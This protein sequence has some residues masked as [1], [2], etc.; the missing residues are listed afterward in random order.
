M[1]PLVGGRILVAKAETVF[2]TDV[3]AGSYIAGDVLPVDPATIRL[4]P[5]LVE[6]INRATMGYLGTVGSSVGSLTGT[7]SWTQGIRGRGA[8][9]DDSPV[10][11]PEIDLGLR[12]CGLGRT[13]VTTGGSESVAY[14]PVAEGS[15]E[16]LT[17]Y[18][19]Q[20]MPSGNALVFKFVGCRGTAR[21]IGDVGQ[22]PDTIEFSLQG[23][24]TGNI[25]IAFTNGTLA[26]TPKFP[27]LASALLQ[28]GAANYAPA[29]S[30]YALDLGNT[31]VR[32]PN[33]NAASGYNGFAITQRQPTFTFDPTMAREADSGWY[34]ALLAGTLVDLTF[35]QGATQ[36]NRKKVKIN[37]ASAAGGQI[38][39]MGLGDRDGIAA[40]DLP[41]RLNISGTGNNDWQ[42]LFD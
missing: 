22:G 3:L 13:I 6:Y 23:A 40:F 31:L 14:Q 28:V 2:G 34:A 29:W 11:V 20:P 21:M 39:G 12:A 36:Y 27:F 42:I 30:R 5:E 8:A 10:V 9:Y 7:I 19:V 37:A 32:E 26:E 4:S 25:D 15:H 18:V 33:G 16:S 17:L 1:P 35:Q 24:F 38:V 41:I